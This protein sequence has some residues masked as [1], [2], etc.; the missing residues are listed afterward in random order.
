MFYIAKKNKYNG[1]VI[2]PPFKPNLG[3]GLQTT[4]K[5][6]FPGVYFPSIIPILSTLPP[7]KNIKYSSMRLLSFIII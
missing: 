4:L 1:S 5:H 2:R 6:I 3:L 7:T